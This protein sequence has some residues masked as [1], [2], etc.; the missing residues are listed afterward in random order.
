MSNC[1]NNECRLCRN[2]VISTAVTVVTIDGTDTLVIDIPSGFYPNCGKICLVVAQTI[3]ETATI[4]MPVSISIGGDTSVV[5]PILNC[6]CTQVT[7]CGIRTRT[8]YA[9]RIS[10]TA[11]S[12][13]FRSLKPLPCYPTQNLTV[14]PTPTATATTFALA[15][16]TEIPLGTTTTKQTTTVTT[17]TK[18]EIN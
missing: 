5:Y 11:T 12:A 18:K 7:A 1:I 10:T 6:D 14:I 15:R 4:T 13:V 2:L 17:T 3:P 9:L 8:K 16:N